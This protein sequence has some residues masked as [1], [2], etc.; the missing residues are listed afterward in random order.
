MSRVSRYRIQ[1]VSE[2]TGVPS[3]TLRAWER[4]YGVP[5]P[6]RTNSAYRL[7]SDE[8]VAQIQRMRDLCAGGL[9]PSEAVLM[10]AL[11]TEPDQE[12]PPVQ[13]DFKLYDEVQSRILQTIERFD[14]DAL[15]AELSR[16]VYLGSAVTIFE[17]VLA[18]TQREVGQRWHEGRITVAQEH[19]TSELIAGVLRDLLRLVQPSQG[20]RALLACVEGEQHAIPLYGVALN[21]AQWGLRP[22]VLGAST[23]PDALGHAVQQLRPELVGLS[24]TVPPPGELAEAMLDAYAA[25]V[26]GRLWLVGG[27]GARQI[28]QSVRSRGGIPVE[29]DV[30]SI[31]GELERALATAYAS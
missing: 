5:A 15:K 14:P 3:S 12:S 22:E 4:R 8:D 11:P 7:Y 21:L 17:R 30:S 23:P 9:T 18:P 16:A 28:A 19:L 31:R 6:E 27:R 10:L 2:M 1:T 25:A 29:T 13:A 26:R 24:V 20:P